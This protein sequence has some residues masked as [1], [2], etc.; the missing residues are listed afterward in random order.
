MSALDRQLAFRE[1]SMTWYMLYLTVTLHM[2][3]VIGNAV[4]FAV[5]P[6]VEPAW[7][8]LPLM[9]F[10]L[11][12]SCGPGHSCPLT[13]VENKIRRE[14]GLI[15]IRGFIGHYILKKR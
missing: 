1:K 3:V 9:S 2:F 6:F 12:V 13:R 7:V 11:F 14:L 15:E 4:S 8:A 10:I 5:L